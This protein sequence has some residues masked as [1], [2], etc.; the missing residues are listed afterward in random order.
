LK[1]HGIPNDQIDAVFAHSAKFFALSSAEK[2]SLAWYSA[3]ANRGYTTLGREKTSMI[4]EPDVAGLRDANPDLKESLEIGRDDQPEYPNMWPPQEDSGDKWA[5]EFKS[6]MLKFFSTCYQFH[7]EVMR[8]IAVGL[9]LDHHWFDDYTNAGDNTLRLLH[10][11]AQSRDVFERNKDQVRAGEHTDYG[12]SCPMITRRSRLTLG[13]SITLLLQDSRG[14][15]QIESPNGNFVDA[16]PI[17]DTIIV[18]AG[19][20]LARW[21]NDLIKSTKH[22]VVEPPVKEDKYPPRYSIAY[23]CNPNFDRM[24]DAIPGTVSSDSPKKYEA[25]NSGDYLIK[26]LSDTY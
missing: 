14:G 18:N 5:S 17:A 4:D 7:M 20:L 2:D 6:T 10:Y 25:I 24:I 8:C 16:T 19:D 11:P 3:A 23:F 12:M 22:R 15:L 9:G 26:R 21:S 1:N 13:G